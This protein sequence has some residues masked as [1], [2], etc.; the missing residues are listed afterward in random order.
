MPKHSDYCVANER[1]KHEYFSYLKEAKRQSEA[2]VDA[3]AMALSRFEKHTGY[4]DFKTFKREQAISFKAWLARQDN[5]ATGSKLSKATLHSTMSYLKGFFQWLAL[6]PSYKSRLSCTDAD[7]FNVS[8]KD[9]RI[10]TARRSRSVPTLEQARTALLNMPHKADVE[11]R[12]RAV[13]A[14]ALLTGARGGAVV[15]AKLKHIDLETGRFFQDAREVDTKNSKTF[16]TYFSPFDDDINNIFA[17]WVHF[18]IS[19]KYWTQQEPLFPKTTTKCDA[20]GNFTQVLSR[21]H[22]AGTNAV[23]RIFRDSF[24]AADMPY[25][26]PHSFRKTLVQIVQRAGSSAEVCKAWSQNLGHEA[27]MTTFYSYGEVPE[28]RQRELIQ[29]A[30]R[31]PADVTL[32]RFTPEELLDEALRRMKG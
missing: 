7:Y 22:W 21:N 6:Q 28:D 19:E 14:F 15:S 4:R 26:N 20:S 24:E 9:A 10:A 17:E 31:G 25:F 5:R 3:V 1:I 11:R 27:L 12:D 29:Q 16:A 13:F 30:P 8:N 32:S 18:L 2:S 23:R